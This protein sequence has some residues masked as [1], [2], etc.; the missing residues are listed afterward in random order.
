MIRTVLVDARNFDDELPAIVEAMAK[1][2]FVGIDCETEDSRRHS[3]LN[4]LMKVDPDGFKAGNTKLLFDARRTT[5]TGFSVYPEGADRAWYV[6]LNHADVVNRVAWAKAQAVLDARPAGACWISHNA[7]YEITMFEAC[8]GRLL[9]NVVCTLQ[10]SVTAFGDDNY[11]VSVFKSSS[12]GALDKWP[13]AMLAASLRGLVTSSTDE[14][15]DD[16]SFKKFNHDVD[17]IISKI[18]S[19]TS[20]AA[21]SYNGYVHSMAYGHGLKQLVR[22]IFGHEMSSFAET[23]GENAHMGQ[24]TGEQVS[25]YGAEDAYWVIPLFRW[26]MDYVATN[27]PD[28]LTTFFEQE[29]PMIYVFSEL[30]RG[31]MRVNLP[32]IGNRRDIERSEFAGLLRSLRACLRQ[33]SWGPRNEELARREAWYDKN[34]QR[35]R[36]LISSWIELEDEDDDLAEACRVS[37]A[38]SNAWREDGGRGSLSISHYMPVRV[39]LYDLLAGKIQ[40]DMGKIASD[41]EARGKLKTWFEKQGNANAV[42]AI[43]CMSAIASVETRMKTYLTPYVL[44]TDPETQRLYPSVSSMLNSRRMAASSPNAMALAK[45]GESTY[46]RGFF[47][48]DDDEHLIVSLDWS[49]IELVIIGEL[50]KDP[51]FKRAFGQLPHADLHTGA[52]T[53]VLQVE[54]PWMTDEI[55]HSCK[56]LNTWADFQDRWSF[57]PGR[58]AVNLKGEAIP[59][60][61]KARSYWRTEI[62]KGANFN[63]WYSGFLTTVGQRMGWDIATTGNATELYRERFAVAEDWRVDL[64]HQGQLNGWIQLPDGHRRFRYEATMEWM[65]WFKAKWPRDELIDPIVHEIAR[66][67]HKRGSNQ[68][69]NSMVQGTCATIMKRSILRMREQLKRDARFMIPIHDEK[70]YSVHHKLVPQFVSTCREVMI[71]HKDLFPTLAL[72]ATPAVGV[73]FEP[74]HIKKAPFGQI[75]LF[76]PPEELGLGTEALD[77]D[78]I[79]EVVRY[80]MRGRE[81]MKMAA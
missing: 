32:A 17:D 27:S 23:L 10:L 81:K 9:D 62:G 52:T 38:V 26:L 42:Q 25:D 77:D 56:R 22:R 18:T 39:L 79:R 31:G 3:G 73:T 24:L 59:E 75:E 47:E 65:D 11:D 60:P 76:E 63:Y 29:N 15:D 66:R 61:G 6:N 34:W 80:L 12:L 54:L 74:W 30:W 21:H 41:G 40:F 35:Y 49:A 45:R 58:F 64:I 46:V 57:E 71:D 43:D 20:T 14:D 16:G 5:M 53:S 67:I 1:A 7:P 36:D 4:Q 51:E 78:G 8:Y 13:R 28:A 69:V 70:V 55:I 48:G 2:S 37:N 19:K 44:L 68:L 50:S 33:C 72:E